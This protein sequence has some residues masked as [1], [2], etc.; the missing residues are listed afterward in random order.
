MMRGERDYLFL[1]LEGKFPFHPQTLH[2]GRPH[3]VFSEVKVRVWRTF[4]RFDIM[5]GLCMTVPHL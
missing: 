5:A 4:C 3:G 1:F 2:L